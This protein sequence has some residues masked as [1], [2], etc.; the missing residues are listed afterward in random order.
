[1]ALT[2]RG[3]ALGRHW[4]AFALAGL[5]AYCGWLHWQLHTVS[6]EM[7]WDASVFRNQV[8]GHEHDLKQVRANLSLLNTTV[9][10]IKVDLG[11]V[12]LDSSYEAVFKKPATQTDLDAMKRDIDTRFGA[13]CSHTR[14]QLCP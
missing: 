12:K 1:V 13:I 14:G 5:A 10:A 2:D 4:Q 3:R 8:D 6:Q 7:E 11:Q 9:D